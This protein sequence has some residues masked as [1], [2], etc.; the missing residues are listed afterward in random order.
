MSDLINLCFSPKERKMYECSFCSWDKQKKCQFAVK[1]SH[2]DECVYFAFEKYCQNWEASDTTVRYEPAT[3]AELPNF[4][5]VLNEARDIIRAA[6]N[7]EPGLTSS[8]IIQRHEADTIRRELMARQAIERIHREAI[9]PQIRRKY[10]NIPHEI[11]RIKSIDD[12]IEIENIKPD[13]IYIDSP[14]LLTA[15]Y[16]DE[17]KQSYAKWNKTDE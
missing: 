2:S 3:E 5:G 12:K 8:E 11:Y 4:S 13:K 1:K 17:N 9:Y 14:P 15:A 10:D 6:Y 16:L 7:G